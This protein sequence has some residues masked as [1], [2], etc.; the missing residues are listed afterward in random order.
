L[1]LLFDQNLSRKLPDLL[2]D[3]FPN[4]SQVF[5]LG[6]DSV[7]DLIIWRYAAEHNLT[8]VSKDGDFA[9]LSAAYGTPPKVLWLKVGNGP[10]RDIAALLQT[11]L[12]EIQVFLNDPVRSML[13][14]P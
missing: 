2:S 1:S 3:V 9:S 4:S 14:L 5:S 6:L 10:T 7:D 12:V 8:I 13:V 11:H